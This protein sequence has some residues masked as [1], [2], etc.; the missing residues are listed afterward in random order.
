MKLVRLTTTNPKGE[1]DAFFRE[2]IEIKPFSK[3]AL[4][5][6]AMESLNNTIVIDNNN[7][8]V[9]FQLGGNNLRTI[10]L[11]NGSYSGQNYKVLL[12]DLQFQLNNIL[13]ASDSTELGKQFRVDVNSAG[14]LEISA[15][16]GLLQ[17]N[18]IDLGDNITVDA[19]S[20]QLLEVNASTLSPT[21][22]TETTGYDRA[23]WYSNS[24]CRGAGAIRARIRNLEDSGNGDTSQGA[25]LWVS[26]TNPATFKDASGNKRNPLLSDIKYGI[27]FSRNGQPYKL[28]IDGVEVVPNTARNVAYTNAGNALNDIMAIEISSGILELVIYSDNGAGGT[29]KTILNTGNQEIPYN[30]TT[31]KYYCCMSIKSAKTVGGV[32]N[33]RLDKLNF[34]RNPYENAP[35]SSGT[36]DLEILSVNPPQVSRVPTNQFFNWGSIDLSEFMGFSNQRIPINGFTNA[37]T[38]IYAGDKQFNF[39]DI[40]DAFLIEMMNHPINSYDGIPSKGSRVNLLSVIPASDSDKQV[41]Y[42]PNNLIFLDMDNKQPLILNNIKARILKSDYSTM[43]IQGLTSLVIYI[44][45]EK[46]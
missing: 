39:T 44:K 42:E 24:L 45:D 9:T 7:N 34:T 14:K 17:A 11:L 2:N 4:G 40:S 12:Q 8:E 1:I 18:L 6:I 31:D 13:S 36:D 28:I 32:F 16:G 5:S 43:N 22:E 3:I 46:E 15:I 35:L 33:C 29:I 23:T 38:I 20:N 19:S 26:L 10:T 30:S 41:I 27:Q 21:L 25:C 37:K